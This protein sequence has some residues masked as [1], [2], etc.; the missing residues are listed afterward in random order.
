MLWF[1]YLY[2]IFGCG[3]DEFMHPETK[4]V[5]NPEE[6]ALLLDH[7]A[8]LLLSLQKERSNFPDY[9]VGIISPYSQQVQVLNALIE[10]H[11]I[12]KDFKNIRVKTIDGFQGRE[13]DIIYLSLV[14]S[15][16]QAEIGFLQDLRR[17]NVALTRAKYKLVVVGDSATI[18]SH[19]FYEAFVDYCQ[20]K[21]INKS[22]WEFMHLK[23]NH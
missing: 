9:S 12:L 17:M 16:P 11:P 1:A 19:P 3:F 7:L 14:R 4:S 21:G 15:N 22:A 23:D 6:D 8:G 18:C 10:E 13:K 5:N 2:L 20:N